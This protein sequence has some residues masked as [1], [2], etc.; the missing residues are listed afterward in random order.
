MIRLLVI[1]DT[2][3]MNTFI[4]NEIE[5]IGEENIQAI[6]HAGDYVSDAE[7]IEALYPRIPMYNVAGNNDIYTRAKGEE[8][9]TIGGVK[10]FITH[11]HA[12]GVKYDAD[13]RSLILRAQALGADIAVFGHTHIAHLSYFGGVTLL[14]PGST[15]YSDR[16]A[17]IEIE[18]GKAN[19]R[20]VK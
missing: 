17:I 4:E 11:G 2:H 1:S 18:N 20:L 3:G 14:N 12:Y 8:F 7:E 5:R 9:V 6:I 16:Y 13:Y 15:G 19:A 10:I